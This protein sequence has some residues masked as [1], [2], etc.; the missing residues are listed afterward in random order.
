LIN[1]KLIKVFI[2]HEGGE[3]VKKQV[4][5]M[6][7]TLFG[8]FLL[9]SSASATMTVSNGIYNVTV[10][11]ETSQGGIGTYT[12][13]T[14]VNH[15]EPNQNVLDGGV[16]GAPMSTYLTV[17]DRT[18][19]VDYVSSANPL[20]TAESGY[21]LIHLDTDSPVVQEISPTQIDTSW[22]IGNV[23]NGGF[24]VLQSIQIVGTTYQDSMVKVN[25]T[26]TNYWEGLT[27]YEI[28]YLWDICVGDHAGAPVRFLDP[29]Q[30][31]QTTEEGWIEPVYGEWQATA[32]TA[33]PTF[34]V[35]GSV[36]NPTGA[37][38]P[39]VIEFVNY[40]N[41]FTHAYPYVVDPTSSIT[42]DTAVLYYFGQ[43]GPHESGVYLAYGESGSATAYLFAQDPS[44][45]NEGSNTQNGSTGSNT[46]TV[47]AASTENTVPMQTTGIPLGML[48]VGVLVTVGGAIYPR[49]K[50]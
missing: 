45:N 36:N 33:N 9:V 24:R 21:T 46:D 12:V 10:E 15:P 38:H 16:E 27:Q 7:C 14:G 25:T 20:I 18:H 28:R 22:M 50:N 31:W 41:S 3:N 1:N 42:D 4:M 29:D 8:I 11:N 2:R 6:I 44:I 49:V 47:S 35:F 17:S 40:D 37:T 34:S 5:L 13:C 39:N 26:I 19:Q 30:A 32:D 48:M 43:L 23:Q